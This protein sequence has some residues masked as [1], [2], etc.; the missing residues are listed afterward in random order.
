MRVVRSRVGIF[1]A[2]EG[3][4]IVFAK[5]WQ[6]KK[7]TRKFRKAGET[8]SLPLSKQHQQFLHHWQNSSMGAILPGTVEDI[9][10]E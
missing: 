7:R 2:L 9:G 6:C 1:V 4:H 10:N 5:L 3:K 8:V